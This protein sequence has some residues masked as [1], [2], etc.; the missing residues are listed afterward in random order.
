MPQLTLGIK[1]LP[2]FKKYEILNFLTSK[3]EVT[4]NE[5]Q[6]ILNNRYH[7]LAIT[8]PISGLFG[9]IM[10]ALF[11][12]HTLLKEMSIRASISESYAGN[13]VQSETFVFTISME[14]TCGGSKWQL[15]QNYFD[16]M[17]SRARRC[18]R[19]GGHAFADE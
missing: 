5:K 19:A 2:N 10:Q 7:F 16:C 8:A 13:V 3:N 11:W 9:E 17:I 4:D 15:I 12:V 14:M 1:I 6:F 18:I